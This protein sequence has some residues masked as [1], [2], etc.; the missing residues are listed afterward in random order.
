M[1]PQQRGD[2]NEYRK[3]RNKTARLVRRD[4]MV[5]NM[6]HLQSQGLNSKV[7][8]NLANTALGRFQ[9]SALPAELQD[10]STGRKVR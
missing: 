3:L 10:V 2:H 9:P 6:R 4:R 8:W 5:S 1:P 7:V